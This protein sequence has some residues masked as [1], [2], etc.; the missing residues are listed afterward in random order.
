MRVFVIYDW[1][2]VLGEQVERAESSSPN[3]EKDTTLLSNLF[4]YS[5]INLLQFR[6]QS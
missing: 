3:I 4:K 6:W 1:I 5:F 2:M